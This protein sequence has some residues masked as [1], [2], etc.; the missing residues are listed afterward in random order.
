[1][2]WL[3]GLSILEAGSADS[4]DVKAVLPSV[5]AEY[6]G[7]I[8]DTTLNAAGD[9][10]GGNIAFWGIEDGAWKLSATYDQDTDTITMS[11]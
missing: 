1:M 9:L 5:A 8:G 6:S 4:G 10:A 7:A 2:V 11:G 3:L